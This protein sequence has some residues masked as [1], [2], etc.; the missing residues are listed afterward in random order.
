MSYLN[1]A[2]N[3]AVKKLV[4]A[5]DPAYRKHKASLNVADT[6]T[7]SGTYWDGGSRSTYTAVDIA[8]GRASTAEQFAPPQF[9]GPS[10]APR[11]AIP[12]GIAIVETG[13]FCGKPAT[14]RV[15][16]NSRT[17]LPAIK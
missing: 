12:D 13:T 9:N 16:V 14:A 4:L 17:M 2:N 1:L 7:L 8:T 11:V 15:T 5:A 3:A 10:A 6:M